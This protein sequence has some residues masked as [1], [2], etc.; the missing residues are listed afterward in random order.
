MKADAP[1]RCRRGLCPLTSWWRL[2]GVGLLPREWVLR[3]L[4]IQQH[5]L[6]VAAFQECAEIGI[7]AAR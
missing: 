7:G 6:K 2:H 3:K 5:V 1:G 4:D